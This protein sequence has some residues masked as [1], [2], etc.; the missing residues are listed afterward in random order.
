MHKEKIILGIDPGTSVMGY[1]LIKAI[2]KKP[3]M[4]TMGILDNGS[5]GSGNT[6]SMTSQILNLDPVSG[7]T[8]DTFVG[9]KE[10]IE[11][12]VKQL[13]GINHFL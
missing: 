1:G 13:L 5:I 2:G 3:E 8:T 7:T 11:H 4:I 12:I 9:S 10:I 6:I